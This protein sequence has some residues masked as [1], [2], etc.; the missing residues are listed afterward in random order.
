MQTDTNTETQLKDAVQLSGATWAVIAER[1]GG[2]WVLRADYH[3]NKAGQLRL[4]EH[5]ARASVDAWLCGA[6][7][8][9]NARSSNLPE[10]TKLDVNRFYAFPLMGTSRVILTGADELSTY[11]QRLWKLTA[12]LLS[13][14]VVSEPQAFLP[15]LQS[16]LAFD[17]PLAIEK[18]LGSFVQSVECQG[19]WIAIRRGDTLDITAEWNDPKARAV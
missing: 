3:L 2:A 13:G 18:V 16:G 9:G 1:V 17:L 10:D 14:R 5:L 7:S 19:A 6:L 15:D 11:G 12:S 8:G 4:I